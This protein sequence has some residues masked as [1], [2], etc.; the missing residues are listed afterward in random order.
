M[1]WFHRRNSGAHGAENSIQISALAGVEPGNPGISRARMLA[2]DYRAPLL[3]YIY[4]YIYIQRR[5]LLICRAHSFPRPAEFRAEPRN[6]G[7]YLRIC[8]RNWATEFV[9]SPRNLTFF[10]RTTIFSQKMTSK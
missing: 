5:G 8:P 7:F 3:I 9:F 2:L 1:L 10:I 6:L 4:I